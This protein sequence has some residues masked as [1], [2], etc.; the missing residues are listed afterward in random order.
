MLDAVD[1]QRSAGAACVAVDRARLTG[2]SQSGSAKAMLPRTHGAVPEIVFLNTS[3]GLTAGD[4]L[5]YEIDLAPGTRATATT[6]TAERAYRA[7]GGTARAGVRLRVGAGGA[8]DWL[9]Q[10][11]ILFDGS[12]LSRETEVDLEGDA[13]FLGVETVVLGR[14]AMGETVA[15]ACFRDTRR[16]RRDGR[17]ELLDPFRLDSAALSRAAG[18]A[19]LNGARAFAV[20]ILSAPAA[21]DRLGDMRAA[22]V[23]PGVEIAASAMPGR[24]ILRALAADAWPLRQQMARL[25]QILRPGGLPRVW[26]S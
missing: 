20:L 23:E 2:L 18:P 10:E 11:T 7:E 15:R 6:Q 25:I 22:E 9:P 1:M 12:A 4:R 8:L 24:L 19:L 5:D 13:A 16:I 17:L 3:G 14:A 26:Q 21:E